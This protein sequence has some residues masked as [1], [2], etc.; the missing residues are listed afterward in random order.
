MSG[1]VYI[2]L[3]AHSAYS[4]L[5]GASLPE[6]LAVRAAELG[7]P[8]IALTDH[9]GVYGSLEFAYAAR[10]AA[11]MGVHVARGDRPDSERL[12]QVA[13]GRVAAGVATNVRALELHV[14]AVSPEGLGEASRRV[15]IRDAEPAARTPR[16]TDEALVQVGEK[17][18]LQAGIEALARVR[19]G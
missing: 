12:R 7:Y 16:E 1:A 6:E 8:A 4:F 2:E 9:D 13:E 3:H 5:D 17:V 15:G 18:W 19:G 10:A 14:E 11:M